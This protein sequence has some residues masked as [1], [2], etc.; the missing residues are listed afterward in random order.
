MMLVGAILLTTELMIPP[1]TYSPT[2]EVSNHFCNKLK[3]LVIYVLRPKQFSDLLSSETLK[4]Q[5]T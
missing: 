5:S 2:A 3:E 1:E 4:A